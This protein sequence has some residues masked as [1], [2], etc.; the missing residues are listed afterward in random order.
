MLRRLLTL[1]VRHP[2]VH[3]SVKAAVA[4][5]LAWLAIVPLGGVADDYPYYAPLGAVICVSTTVANT[6]RT[7]V[8][9][10]VAILLGALLAMAARAA[11]LQ[12]VLALAFVVA[13]GTL[14]G[15]WRRIAAMASYVPVAALFVLILGGRDPSHYVIGY[16]GLTTLGGAIGIA[17]N[18]AFPSLPLSSTQHTQDSLR[19][20]LADQLDDLADGLEQDR[21][22]SPEEWSKRQWAIS[23]RA[24][25]MQQMVQEA[26]EARRANWRA[27]RWAEEADRVYQQARALEQLAF[28]V[29]DITVLVTRSEHS[30]R[31]EVAL[32]AALR[33]PAAN[34]L[35]LTATALR[36]VDEPDGGM[37][38]QTAAHE[39]VRQ[40]AEAIIAARAGT[41][42]ELFAAGTVV[43]AL[44]RALDALTPD[45]QLMRMP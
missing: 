35:R 26:T 3:V 14:L 24:R 2:R 5:T 20:T 19:R 4:A 42:E 43:T 21:L 33:P 41:G 1:V 11:D 38:A 34:A 15:G 36:S 8:Q 37:G 6:M 13:V 18:A 25:Q 40:L 30:D 10:G 27:R 12:P 17:I 28:L 7:A 45:A 29:E 39:A 9:A 32:G 16:L 44:R 23:P 31:H 22:L